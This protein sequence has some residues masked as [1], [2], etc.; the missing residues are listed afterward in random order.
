MAGF[1]K[2]GI[3]V[4][5]EA[6]TKDNGLGGLE[7][8]LSGEDKQ[9]QIKKGGSKNRSAGNKHSI[10]NRKIKKNVMKLV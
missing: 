8:D 1:S 4:A 10:Y 7:N 5:T 6:Q 9:I 3:R 2:G